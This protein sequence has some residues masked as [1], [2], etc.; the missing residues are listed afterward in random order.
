MP[1]DSLLTPSLS[2]SSSSLAPPSTGTSDQDNPD[3]RFPCPHERCAARVTDDEL[4]GHYFQKHTPDGPA[5]EYVC[6][7]T[8][9][10]IMKVGSRIKHIRTKHLHSLH[11]KCPIGNQVFSRP[12]AARRHLRKKLGCDGTCV[13]SPKER[14]SGKNSKAK[15]KRGREDEDDRS[16]WDNIDRKRA[17]RQ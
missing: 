7:G 15:G 9:D 16:N 5:S 17:R 12:D 14:Q 13:G 6:C 11:T 1:Y 8:C 10:K 3:H 2:S 4:P